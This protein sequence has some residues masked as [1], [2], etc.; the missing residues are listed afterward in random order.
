ML[1]GHV[2]QNTGRQ[3]KSA[4]FDG[5]LI[6]PPDFSTQEAKGLKSAIQFKC[7]EFLCEVSFPTKCSLTGSK[8]W[9]GIN[10][11][12]AHLQ[13][14]GPI[15][16]STFFPH[17]STFLSSSHGHFTLTFIRFFYCYRQFL[18][19]TWN[20][21]REVKSVSWYAKSLPTFCNFHDFSLSKILW[22]MILIGKQ[23]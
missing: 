7:M 9:M 18:Q 23:I 20:Y 4:M 2:L 14:S 5:L 13:Q 8:L 6:Q 1:R 12:S 11:C 21:I 22:V 3:K 15:H 10:F 16:F 19:M 17:C